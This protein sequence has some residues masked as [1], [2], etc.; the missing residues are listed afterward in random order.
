MSSL[1]GSLTDLLTP[2][3]LATLSKTLNLDEQTIQQGIGVAGPLLLQGLSNQSQ[4][5]AGLDAIMGM[6]PAD[7]TAETAN[8]LGQV[9]KLFGGSGATLASAGMLNSIFSAGLPAISKTL[10]DRLG[11]DVTPLIAAAAPML[12]G[13]LKQRAAD[14]T[15]DSNAIAHLLQTEAA[16]TRAALAPDV[17]AALTGAFR[18][19]EEAE[20]VRSAFSDD[21]WAKVRLAP[22][23]ATYYVMSAS[24]SGMVGSVQEITGAG[25]AMK[26]LLA[27]SAATSLVNVAF[28]AVSAGFEGD[29][30]L[31]QQADRAEF[32][33]LLQTAAAAVKR[34]APE[35]A[36]AFAAVITSLGTTV[37]EAA[38]EGGF[39][40]IG[41]KKISKDEQQALSEI[42]AAV[43]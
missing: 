15:L 5:T 6:L 4:S 41:A 9:L 1:I 25:D 12:L 7:D 17:D 2:Q 30:G 16:A 26:D 34:S 11:F 38:K 14:E 31:D 22:L 10:R 8:M 3:A 35:D 43:A 40:G 29:S 18:A 23:A 13:L 33:A 32:L 21:D 27:N 37:A 19:A 28:G 20:Q 39:L 24:P 42:A 36:A